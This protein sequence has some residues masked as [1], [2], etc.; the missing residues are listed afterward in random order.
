MSADDAEVQVIPQLVVDDGLVRF[1]YP[2][3]D[4]GDEVI[5]IESTGKSIT[6][7]LNVDL[8]KVPY[9]IWYK[10]TWYKIENRDAWHKQ[11]FG[12]VCS[13]LETQ[14]ATF[15]IK[16]LSGLDEMIELDRSFIWKK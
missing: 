2:L 8:Q 5:I 7:Q 6:R 1:G 12:W 3:E 9:F 13:V 10:E 11:L 14:P 16:A 4:R 15:K